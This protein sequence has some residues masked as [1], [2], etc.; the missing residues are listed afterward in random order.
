MHKMKG[1]NLQGKWKILYLFISI[2]HCCWTISNYFWKTPIFY[3]F[4][5]ILKKIR[6]LKKII[7]KYYF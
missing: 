7:I 4:S 6:E 1:I 2:P 3:P 5:L